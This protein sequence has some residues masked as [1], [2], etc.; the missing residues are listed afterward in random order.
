MQ[1]EV[2]VLGATNCGDNHKPQWVCVVCRVAPFGD[3]SYA[4]SLGGGCPRRDEGADFS[5]FGLTASCLLFLHF[6]LP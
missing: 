1:Q 3:T 6:L 4:C 5:A 2:S